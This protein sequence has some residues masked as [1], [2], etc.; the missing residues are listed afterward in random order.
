MIAEFSVWPLGTGNASTSAEVA[1]VIKLIHESGMPYKLNAMS[2]VVEGEWPEVMGL[3]ERCHKLVSGDVER[4]VT[5]ITI[6][7]RK[8]RTER[9]TKKIES[10]E[11]ILGMEVSK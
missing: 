4:V 2:T 8:G 10:V 1:K 6:D 7:D 5:S 3:I 9:I 11:R